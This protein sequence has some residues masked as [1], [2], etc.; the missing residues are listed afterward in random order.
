MKRT[1][2]IAEAGVN[3]NG[4]IELAKSLIEEAKLAGA[5]YIKFQ[6]FKTELSISPNAL[7]AEYQKANT[8]KDESQYE[9]VKKLEF[10]FDQFKFLK[11]YC[12]RIGIGF[13]STAFDLPSLKLIDTL[14]SFHK[15]PSGEITNYPYLKSMA[16]IGKPV[17]LST[18]MSN[19]DEINDAL[20]I[21]TEGIESKHITI[22][23]CNTEYPT[24]MED[25][26][27][28]AMI[29]L[30]SKFNMKVGYS[31][32]TVGIEVPIA[33]AAIGACVIEK[34]F[35]LSRSLPG[36]DH[37]SSL[38]PHELRQMIKSIRNIDVA[39]SGDGVKKPSKS[40][41]KNILVARKSIFSSKKLLKDT[42]LKESDLLTLRPGDGISPMRWND[43]VGRSLKRD[44]KAYEKLNWK[45]I[46]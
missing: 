15:I 14:Q 21:L 36:P 44:I 37:S 28:L 38:E 31:D 29:S 3:H 7:K 19:M 6:T 45:D 46:E 24:P 34:H 2:I 32:H 18:G 4:E 10:S 27:L 30:K 12:D 40:E 35:T 43:V 1:I 9:M 20:L 26:N 25:V 41:S 22:L 11:K 17:L 5:D 33:A 8:T 13:L 16:S 39:I 23:H 42:V